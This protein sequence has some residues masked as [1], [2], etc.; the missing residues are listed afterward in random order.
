MKFKAGIIGLGNIGLLYDLCHNDNNILTHTGAY[1]K[2]NK[3]NLLFGVDIDT[4]KRKLFEKYAGKPV[5]C[6]LEEAKKRFNKV[7]VVS[8]CLPVCLRDKVM[9]QVTEFYPKVIWLEKPLADDS[10]N[11]KR[12]ID[13]ARKNGISLCVNYLRRFEKNTYLLKDLIA[14]KK[15]GDIMGVTVYYNDGFYNNAS[16]YIDFLTVLLGRHV[17]SQIVKIKKIGNDYEIDFFLNF[18]QAEVFFK[19]IKADSPIGEID[20]WFSK[21]RIV[22][23][24]FGLE[25]DFYKMRRDKVFKQLKEISIYKTIKSGLPRVMY[26]VLDN[27]NDMLLGKEKLQSDGNSA[28][29]TFKT[30]ESILKND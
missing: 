19:V 6:S 9:E 1:L 21:G 8:I 17:S 27:I 13:S 20:I 18:P 7:D 4:K 23:K 11:A 30:C 25:I 14:K 16:H 10:K 3:F 24:K 15:L 28:M 22:Y 12:I 29:E 2:H 5:F 26:N